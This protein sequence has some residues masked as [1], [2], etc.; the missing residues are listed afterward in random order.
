MMAPEGKLIIG[1]TGNIAT[2]KS[3]IMKMAQEHGALIIDADKVVHEILAGDQDVQATVIETFGPAVR[4]EDG[5]INRAALG[6]IVFSD[7]Q[8]LAALEAIVHPAVHLRVLAIIR[9]STVPVV[10]IEAIKLLEGKLRG[11]CHSIWVT[12]CSR[13]QQ[14]QRLQVCRGLDEETAVMRVEAQAPQEEKL[15]QADVVI[16]T[17]GL[18]GDTRQQFETAW[19]K[20]RQPD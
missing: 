6:K 10:M 1:L 14:L 11:M 16:H 5:G 9:D 7:S 13:E 8:A 4:Q 19:A 18:M 15:R 2:G 3:A 20:L 17:G 12:H